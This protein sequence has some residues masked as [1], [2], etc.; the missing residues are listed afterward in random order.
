MVLPLLLVLV[1]GIIEAG[2]FFAQQVE[3]R[4]AAREGARLAVVDFPGPDM[5]DSSEILAETCARADLSGDGVT[6]TI[7]KNDGTSTGPEDDT[8]I[9]T[10]SHPYQSLT[11]FIPGFDDAVIESTVEMRSERDELTWTDIATPTACP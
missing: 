4:N 9:V 6:I 7:V 2:W 1:F 8:A 10:V 11:G 3:V 5:G